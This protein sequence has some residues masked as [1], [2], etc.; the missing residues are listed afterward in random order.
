MLRSQYIHGS[1]PT[2]HYLALDP[3]YKNPADTAE[4]HGLKVTI[5]SGATWNSQME[6]AELIP[7]TTANLG[8]GNLFYHFSVSRSDT[9]APDVCFVLRVPVVAQLTLW[10]LCS[11]LW[12]TKSCSSNPTSRSSSTVSGPPRL[13]SSGWSEV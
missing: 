10:W 7:Q 13:T 11:R 9:N 6:R 8:Q 3:A 5:D 2:S 12:N 4:T 1:Q